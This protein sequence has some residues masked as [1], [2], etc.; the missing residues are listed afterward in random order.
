MCIFCEVLRYTCFILCPFTLQLP[1]SHL[2]I[3]DVSISENKP[4][5]LLRIIYFFVYVGFL[6]GFTHMLEWR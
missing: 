6:Q 5:Q 2:P 1:S 3:D 4:V